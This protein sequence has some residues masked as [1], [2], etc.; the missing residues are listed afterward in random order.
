M[1]LQQNKLLKN[2]L[3]NNRY[4]RSGKWDDLVWGF[5]TNG[6][7][8]TQAQI[9]GHP[10]DIDLA[11]NQTMI[12]GNLIFV[13]QNGDGIIDWKDQVVI[14]QSGMPNGTLVHL[15]TLNGEIGVLMR[16]FKE[17]QDIQP[18]LF[19]LL[20]MVEFLD[21]NPLQKSFSLKIDRC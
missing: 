16:Y 20:D 7:F 5:Q 21:T 6:F 19:L 2:I 15:Q 18:I 3:W 4:T 17:H 14:G 9:D 12:V 10:V 13:D 1:T 8:T 11:G